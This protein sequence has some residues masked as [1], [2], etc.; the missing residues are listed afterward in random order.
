MEKKFNQ[1]Y[2]SK[3]NFFCKILCHKKKKLIRKLY[4]H[5]TFLI[6]LICTLS[7]LVFCSQG[8]LCYAILKFSNLHFKL[9]YLINEDQPNK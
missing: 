6:A 1:R 7:E 8:S 5:I 4:K 2:N 3:F 9:N